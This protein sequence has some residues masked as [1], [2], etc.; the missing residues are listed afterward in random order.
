VSAPRGTIRDFQV[1]QLPEMPGAKIH[2]GNPRC[3][4]MVRRLLLLNGLATIAAVL[5]HATTWELT[6][7]FWWADRYSSAKV[8]DFTQLWSL[9]YTALRV[10]DQFAVSG[11]FAFLLVSGYFVAI[12]G[13]TPDRTPSWRLIGHRCKMLAI[14]YLIWSMIYV[15]FAAA[16]GRHFGLPDLGWILLTGGASRPFYYVPLLMQLYV[17]APFIIPVA[18][19]RPTFLLASAFLLSIP[20]TLAH[21]LIIFRV[22]P[23]GSDR[24]LRVLTEWYPPG[25]CLWFALGMV[26]AL[27]VDRVKPLLHRYR[28]VLLA[29][30]LPIMAA[31][32]AEWEFLRRAT[33]REWTSIQITVTGKIFSLV[34]ILAFF[35]FEKLPVPASGWVARVGTKSFGVYLI[36]VLFLELAARGTYHAAPWLLRY[37]TPFLL[38]LCIVGI[39]VPLLLMNAVDRIPR[40]R[41]FYKYLFG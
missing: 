30:L 4:D 23:H 33:G 32:F 5:H 31:G 3:Y 35:A 19:L 41:G 36:H 2:A 16:Q 14:P 12:A 11:V 29:S 10:L 13:G 40:V 24:Y 34:L 21:H 17:I 22:M 37:G 27:H 1:V 38:L 9:R 39:A 18:R 15:A 6:A 25:Y 28:Y 8:P 20:V 26:I 7:I